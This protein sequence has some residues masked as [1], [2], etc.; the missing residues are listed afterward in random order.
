[1]SWLRPKVSPEVLEQ[2]KKEDAARNERVMK[3]SAENRAKQQA[4]Y[5]AYQKSLVTPTQTK[6]VTEKSG[7]QYIVAAPGFRPVGRGRKTHRFKKARS[8][9]SLKGRKTR[10]RHK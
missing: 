7:S 9:R 5:D 1:M 10:R 4:A 8:K 3:E 2:R 6:P